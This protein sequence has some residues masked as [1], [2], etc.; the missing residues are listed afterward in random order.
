MVSFCFASYRRQQ[1][2]AL[3]NVSSHLFALCLGRLVPADRRVVLGYAEAMLIAYNNKNKYRLPMRKLY[4]NQS[5]E[6]LDDE[7]TS[8]DTDAT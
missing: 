2:T 8:D 1:T 4:G 3:P 7:E 5:D 6:E